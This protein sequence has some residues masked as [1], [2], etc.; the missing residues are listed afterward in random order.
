MNSY[1]EGR[2]GLTALQLGREGSS[3]LGRKDACVPD[4]DVKYRAH[5]AHLR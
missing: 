4:I 3:S 5:Q 1:D 2:G